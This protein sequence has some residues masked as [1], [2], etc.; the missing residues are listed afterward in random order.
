MKIRGVGLDWLRVRV[1]YSYLAFVAIGLL[2]FLRIQR[3]IHWRQELV[4]DGYCIAIYEGAGWPEHPRIESPGDLVKQ[5]K[6]K[7]QVRATPK[8]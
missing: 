2:A 6:I 8:K 7:L 4:C 5:L 3:F 1:N